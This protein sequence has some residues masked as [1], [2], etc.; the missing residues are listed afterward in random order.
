MQLVQKKCNQNFVK[1]AFIRVPIKMDDTDEAT[2]PIWIVSDESINTSE[3]Q[4]NN[5][6]PLLIAKR[7]SNNRD[8]AQQSFL[9]WLLNKKGYQIVLYKLYKGGSTMYQ[10][11][12]VKRI[13]KGN[14]KIFD[15]KDLESNCT[16]ELKQ[17]RRLNDINTN[18][19]LI[20]I[21]EGDD[22]IFD[23][24]KARSTPTSNNTKMVRIISVITG[25]EMFNSKMIQEK[26]FNVNKELKIEM[27]ET[28]KKHFCVHLKTV[29]NE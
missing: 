29:V 6:S 13:Y 12:K 24:K 21:L 9:I 19:A 14:N 3:K 22:V 26:G 8:A 18:N 15:V 16:V 5:P 1:S 17:R 28:N 10:L 4:R 7:E 11:F 20:T 25:N 2:N 27:K 23:K